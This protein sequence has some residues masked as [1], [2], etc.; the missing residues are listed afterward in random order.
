MKTS[1][2]DP[3]SYARVDHEVPGWFPGEDLETFRVLLEAQARA[4][5]A[6]D[7]LEIGAYQGR[8]AIL[9]GFYQRPDSRLLVCDVFDEVK[10]GAANEAENDV[11]Y[12][13]LTRAGF[14]EHYRR[15]H[16]YDPQLEVCLSQ[17]L[18]D[19]VPAGSVRFLHL[20]GSHLYE[21]V[22][23]DLELAEMLLSPDGV[24]VIDDYRSPH[25]PGVAAAAWRALT[26]GRLWP[27]RLTPQK[28]YAALSA[29]AASAVG[30][31]L[32]AH[33]LER[34]DLRQTL[35]VIEGQTV[36]VLYRPEVVPGQRRKPELPREV[37]RRAAAEGARALLDG[38]A[39]I[40]GRVAGRVRA[41]ARG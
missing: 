20:D 34:A 9:L 31:A 1:S 19:R 8:T 39:G 14:L 4:G 30:G 16:A 12:P 10:V 33:T 36:E 3:A 11:S 37:L 13:G 26:D 2:W 32:A 29:E 24:L 35:E 27:V 6:G 15:F 21:V 28:M 17:E 25:T 5:T 40:A 22:V 41:P 18:R 7:L 23:R 38:A